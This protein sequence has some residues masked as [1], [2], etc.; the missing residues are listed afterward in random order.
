[1]SMLDYAFHAWLLQ[2]AD[3]GTGI[4]WTNAAQ[5]SY[6]TSTSRKLVQ[7]YL[8][9]LERGRYIK[10]FPRPRSHATYPILLN[11]FHCNRF[12]QRGMILNA[13]KTIDWRQPVYEEVSRAVSREVSTPLHKERARGDFRDL[14]TKAKSKTRPPTPRAPAIPLPVSREPEQ[15]RKIAARDQRLE[16]EAEVRRET[17]VGGQAPIAWT[18]AAVSCL[19]CR[20]VL[21]ELQ[22]ARCLKGKGP[23]G[24]QT[25]CPRNPKPVSKDTQPE[26]FHRA[27][28]GS[29]KSP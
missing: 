6:E 3:P 2:L 4:L 25:Y 23:W 15:R 26:H 10:R 29:Q 12:P 11:R 22:L 20:V 1:M 28:A 13:L 8:C 7:K 27:A 24:S 16:R 17:H 19:E 9:R 18:A 14:E 21:N 5:L